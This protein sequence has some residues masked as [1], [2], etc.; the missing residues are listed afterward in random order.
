LRPIPANL[1]QPVPM[2]YAAETLLE[3]QQR[4]EA[5]WTPLTASSL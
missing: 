2:D 1:P 5:R 3:K 4:R